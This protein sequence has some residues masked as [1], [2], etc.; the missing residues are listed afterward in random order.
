MQSKQIHG[1]SQISLGKM[2]CTLEMK[3]ATVTDM[4][5]MK[6]ETGVLSLASGMLFFLPAQSTLHG[7]ARDSARLTDQQ[8][9]SFKTLLPRFQ[10]LLRHR[11]IKNI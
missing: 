9:T 10:K 8:V 2:S 3:L 11:K 4:S 6:T 5:W 1:R 7:N